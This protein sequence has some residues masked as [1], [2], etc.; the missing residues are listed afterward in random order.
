MMEGDLKDEDYNEQQD[1]VACPQ[2]QRQ[3]NNKKQFKSN[4]SGN[5]GHRMTIIIY[6]VKKQT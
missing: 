5:K 4:E 2:F 1:L 3:D 6:G